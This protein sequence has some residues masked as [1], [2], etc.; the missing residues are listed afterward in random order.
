MDINM[1]MLAIII[2]VILSCRF[3]GLLVDVMKM[4][5]QDQSDREKRYT[6]GANFGAIVFLLVLI[7]N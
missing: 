4:E 6:L 1:E 2:L 3:P 7:L 5:T